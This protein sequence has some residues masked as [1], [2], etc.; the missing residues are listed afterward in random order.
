VDNALPPSPAGQLTA[1]ATWNF[2]GWFRDPPAGG[3]F[4]D[5]SDG[6]SIT[7]VP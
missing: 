2:Q 5:L 3:A 4:F 6:Y 1:G 7:F